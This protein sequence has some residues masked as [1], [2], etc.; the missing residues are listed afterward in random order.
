[1]N[2]ILYI[3]T[4]VVFFSILDLRHALREKKKGYVYLY[5]GMM[6]AV[7]VLTVVLSRQV[8]I[9]GP[10]K[11]IQRGVEFIVGPME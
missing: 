2:M 11:P 10:N 7:M 3:L 1:M 9:P 5:L 6:T 4:A 8:E